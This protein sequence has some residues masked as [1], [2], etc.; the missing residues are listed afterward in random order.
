M[1][2]RLADDVVRMIRS[3]DG[4]LSCSLCQ[5]VL[6]NQGPKGWDYHVITKDHQIHLYRSLVGQGEGSHT[7]MDHEEPSV[8]DQAVQDPTR[9]EDSL[10]EAYK[11]FMSELNQQDCAITPPP[12]EPSFNTPD[13]D[14]PESSELEVESEQKLALL[15]MR[16]STF[17]RLR[18]EERNITMD[19][20][21]EDESEH[22]S[23]SS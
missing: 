14:E 18:H 9:N 15:R 6:A 8:P 1:K 20:S 13:P 4:V 16:I 22:T 21:E 19:T 23:A 2:N 11:T 12:P 5:T 17:K 3:K 10:E 7:P